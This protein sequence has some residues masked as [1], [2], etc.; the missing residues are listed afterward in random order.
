[1]HNAQPLSD[2]H[3]KRSDYPS[4]SSRQ[5]GGVMGVRMS[6]QSFEGAQPLELLTR[7]PPHPPPELTHTVSTTRTAAAQLQ[8]MP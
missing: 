5:E 6:L 1:M 3:P 4:I 8:H 7:P 2:P